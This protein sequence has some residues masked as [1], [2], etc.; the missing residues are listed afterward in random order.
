[1]ESLIDENGNE[2]SSKE[3]VC[4]TAKSFYE[5][6]LTE[7]PID[8]EKLQREIGKHINKKLTNED[9]DSIEGPFTKDEIMKAIKQMQNNKSLGLD[10]LTREFYVLMWDIIWK[11]LIDVITNIYFSD[12]MPKS[13]TEGLIVLIYICKGDIQ[14]LKNWRPITLLN[15]DYKIM[16]KALGNRLK[17]VSETL[18]NLDQACSIDKR[19]IHDQLYFIGEFLNYFKED[20]R[21][22]MIIA[23]DQEKALDRVNHT[24]LHK[25]LE[26]FNFGPTSLDLFKT[27]Y[28]KMTSGS[29]INGFITDSL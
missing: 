22:G 27:I 13:W 17:K 29:V 4:R 3:E 2:T 6:L 9:R 25:I 5:K 11:D 10:A 19:N 20:K 23:I 18:V 21:T 24:L 7:E 1:M 26:K 16:T 8:T 15:T 28:Q 14:D 12:T